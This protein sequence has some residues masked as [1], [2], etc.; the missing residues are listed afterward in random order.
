[1]SLKQDNNRPFQESSPA[2]QKLIIPF[3]P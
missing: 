1:V 2:K 3:C